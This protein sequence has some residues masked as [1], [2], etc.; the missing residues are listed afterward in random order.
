MEKAL[1]WHKESMEKKEILPISKWEDDRPESEASL[2]IA[3]KR[4][5]NSGW[6]R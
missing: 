3:E 6:V 1:Q 2:L 5:V 4:K